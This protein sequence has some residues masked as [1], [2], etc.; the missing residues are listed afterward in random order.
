MLQILTSFCNPAVIVI[1]IRPVA[2][3]HRLSTVLPQYLFFMSPWVV[4]LLFPHYTSFISV[5]LLYIGR[6]KAGIM[7]IT[8]KPID[9]QKATL[10]APTVAWAAFIV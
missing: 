2:L 1:N 5:P 6:R 4:S 8:V 7:E 10:Y 3:R 9:H